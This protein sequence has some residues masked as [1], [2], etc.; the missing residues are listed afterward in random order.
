MPTILRPLHSVR[1]SVHKYAVAH[2]FTA[3]IVTATVLCGGYYTYATLTSTDG[4][5]SYVTTMAATST[6]IATLSESGQVSATSE[7]T[8]A[9]KAAGTVLAIYVKPG[10]HV[11]AGTAIA[12]ID[13]TD[14]LKAVRDAELSLETARLTY[15]KA[16]ESAT[17]IELLQAKNAVAN[18]EITL[19]KTR[20]TSYASIASIYTDLGT[21]VGGIDSVL[22]ESDVTGRENQ[23]NIDAYADLVSNNDT[24]ISM[25]KHSAEDSYVAAVTAYNTALATYKATAR[26][27]SNDELL[28]LAQ[29]TYVAAQAVA[30]ATKNTHD[31]FDRVSA[32][33][34]LYNLGTSPVLAGLIVSV[35]GYT[36]TINANLASALG[37]KTNIIS[38]EQTL[39]VAEDSLKT[40]DEGPDELAT[41]SAVLTLKKA[42]ETL[43]TANE[44]LADTIV[45]APFSGTLAAIAVD[46]YQTVGSGT[47]IATMVSDNKV[48]T[49]SVSEAD[50]TAIKPGQK[51]TLT[52]DALPDSMI[53]G[54]VA[55]I[56]TSGSVSSGV[57]SYSVDVSLDTQNDSVKPGMSVTAD[58]ITGTATGIAI[59]N[60]AVKTS[61]TSNYVLVFD[62]ALTADA[63]PTGG[64]ATT[65]TPTKVPVTIGLAGSTKTIIAGGLVGGEQ[66]VTKTT[67]GT[68]AKAATP[69]S[70]SQ[71]GSAGSLRGI[72][73]GAGSRPPGM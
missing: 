32:D 5:T 20:D 55:S 9:S 63:T 66:V 35:N 64:T 18:A 37:V 41:K 38:A 8:I 59:P 31:F 53:T 24:S 67:A 17:D 45:R 28:K 70:A 27:V 62:P 36:T 4:E 39:A 16:V 14:A 7:V 44:D 65:R 47:A 43:D 40:T 61:G 13:A 29:T 52:F 54:T 73:G 34:T 46:Q 25:Y 30:D 6:V 2:K 1:N 58:I 12:K 23:E 3:A 72:T 19:D 57:V 11:G 49:L 22:H 51:A 50:A 56:S 21:V 42:Q 71:G 69:S 33:Y 48:A 60:S 10:T 26:G 68:A 15:D